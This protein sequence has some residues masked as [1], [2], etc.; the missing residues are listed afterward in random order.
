MSLTDAIDISVN[1]PSL[2]SSFTDDENE[3]KEEDLVYDTPFKITVS[4]KIEGGSVLY[5]TQKIYHYT[6]DKYDPNNKYSKTFLLSTNS[7]LDDTMV[8]E[9]ASCKGSYEYKINEVS[10]GQIKSTPIKYNKNSYNGK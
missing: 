7:A 10:E 3:Y 8:I 1:T 9:I 2:S 5:T 6:T 4:P